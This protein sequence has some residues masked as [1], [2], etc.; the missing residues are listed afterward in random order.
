MKR[1]IAILLVSS[2][3][4]SLVG[5]GAADKPSG[6]G[7]TT[8][9]ATT[10]TAISVDCEP[11]VTCTESS[12]STSTTTT[13]KTTSTRQKTEI[14]CDGGATTTRTTATT[15]TKTTSTQEGPITYS[16][17]K[18]TLPLKGFCGLSNDNK[19]IIQTDYLGYA[20]GE[21]TPPEAAYAYRNGEM[22]QLKPFDF[23]LTIDGKFCRRNQEVV[24]PVRYFVLDSTVHAYAMEFPGA[25]THFFPIPNDSE[26]VLLEGGG[27]ER[28]LKVNV[29][30]GACELLT[31][32]HA[33]YRAW[34]DT[35]SDD[36]KYMV[37][38]A[39]LTYEV[40]KEPYTCR[41]VYHLQSGKL[42]K[43]PM[44]TNAWCFVGDSL[45][46]RTFDSSGELSVWYEFD[47]LTGESLDWRELSGYVDRDAQYR[48]YRHLLYYATAD[49]LGV[50]NL[51]T[52][53]SYM[54]H[55]NGEKADYLNS[56]KSGDVMRVYQRR[57]GQ[58]PIISFINMKTGK[59]QLL[60]DITP[61]YVDGE[62]KKS[63]I[64]AIE[65]CDDNAVLITYTKDL[66]DANLTH[67]YAEV[68]TLP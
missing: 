60:S 10:T 61:D 58:S 40:Q 66:D 64:L 16:L 54:V 67:C 44:P 59:E 9:I 1:T 47:L 22:I 28:M 57:E 55:Y 39:G 12:S 41:Y 25:A 8:Q 15:T 24:V 37:M 51:K 19:I 13:Q 29:I 65:W 32:E 27:A 49:K 53:Q 42:T 68:I 18:A 30:T 48:P 35:L 4:F 5:C 20:S 23:T 36:G 52:E 38:N 62:Y 63:R 14:W 6:T 56:N 50:F 26:H 2:M 7:T 11:G 46:G 17:G 31:E 3:I 45:F 21:L 33:D 34:E 43:L